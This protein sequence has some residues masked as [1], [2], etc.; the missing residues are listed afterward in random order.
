MPTYFP[1]P[2]AGGGGGGGDML[3]AD[4]L[5]GLAS[6]ATSRTNL[7]L[8]TISI[9]N[10][11][12]FLASG[13]NLSEVTPSTART[14]LGLGTAAVQN[15]GAFAQVANNLSDVTAATARN[16]LGLTAIAT[17]STVPVSSGGT[18]LTSVGS[19]NT[20]LSTNNGATGLEY[21]SVFAGPGLTISSTTGRLA[22][23]GVSP[24]TSGNG[25]PY[26]L[27]TG[28]QFYTVVTSGNY[29]LSVVSGTVGQ[30]FRIR[31]IQDSTGGRTISW[32][33]GISW[34][35]GSVPTFSTGIGKADWFTFIQTGTN[36]Y[37]GAQAI[38]NL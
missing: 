4:N 3:K 18:A 35:S 2:S 1:P 9:H 23:S 8:G 19:A 28:N 24:L 16:N 20:L 21:K 6:T 30:N 25:K 37:D 5:A 32:W 10:S 33:S 36:T 34:P 22:I 11:G 7:G 15:V 31:L 26:D 17:V 29:A 27:S 13:N 12:A 14:N 38:I